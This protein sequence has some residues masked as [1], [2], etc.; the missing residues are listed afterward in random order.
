VERN[1]YDVEEKY[2]RAISKKAPYISP[3]GTFFAIEGY[4]QAI[5]FLRDFGPLEHH[6]PCVI[7]A[8]GLDLGAP[9]DSGRRCW[10][11]L[12]EFWRRQRRYKTAVNL[13][14]AFDDLERLKAAWSEIYW[15]EIH[16]DLDDLDR[17]QPP[18]LKWE[19]DHILVAGDLILRG[20]DIPV[21]PELFEEWLE[22]A[23]VEDLKLLALEVI[24]RELKTFAGN[25]TVWRHCIRDG[26]P[27]FTLVTRQ[28]S[29]WSAMWQFFARDSDGGV[30]WRI[31]PHCQKL[32]VPP[33]KDRMCCTAR[34]QELYSKRIWWAQN[35]GKMARLKRHGRSAR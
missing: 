10:V 35:R 13:Y 20:Q 16:V 29:L 26:H 9:R 25:Q 4:Y 5:K 27:V 8:W 14:Q 34:I 6:A 2:H 24:T 15:N 7:K 1:P 21:R 33:R 32:F 3:H 19:K 12:E 28:T 18:L 22:K 11:N 30:K 17:I 23:S 31:C